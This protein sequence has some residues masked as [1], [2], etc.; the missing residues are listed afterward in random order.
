MRRFSENQNFQNF[1]NVLGFGPK[2]PIFSPNLA[3]W[4]HCAAAILNWQS[5]KGVSPCWIHGAFFLVTS[6]TPRSH[7]TNF[8]LVIN[9]VQVLVVLSVQR[10]DYN[11]GHNIVDYTTYLAKK[12]KPQV[13]ENQFLLHK[14]KSTLVVYPCAL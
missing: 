12:Y 9:F 7:L 11:L 3:F 6:Y 1:Q 2:S 4:A 13:F 14:D 8:Q 10:L 5:K